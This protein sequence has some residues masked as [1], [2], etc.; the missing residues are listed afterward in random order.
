MFFLNNEVNQGIK[1]KRSEVQSLVIG[2]VS[3]G[4]GG[5]NIKQGCPNGP[6]VSGE[7]EYRT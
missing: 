3:S 4:V 1:Y 7:N 5:C 2:Y 6:G